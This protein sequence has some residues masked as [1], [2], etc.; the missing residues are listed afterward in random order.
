M[1]T[2]KGILLLLAAFVFG[3]SSCVSRIDC[4]AYSKKEEV[5]KEVRS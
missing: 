4:P 2:Q 3:L 5:K 1:K